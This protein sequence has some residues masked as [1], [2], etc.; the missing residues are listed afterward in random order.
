MFSIDKFCEDGYLGRPAEDVQGFCDYMNQFQNVV[1]WGAGNLGEAIGSKFAQLG[2]CVSAY[3]DAKYEEKKALNGIPVIAPFSGAF[4]RDSTMVVFC[5]ANVPMAP[6]LFAKLD[7]NGWNHR[8]RGLA[9]LQALLCPLEIGKP[10]DPGICAKQKICTVCS[11]ER[12]SSLMKAQAIGHGHIREEDILSFDRVHFIVNNFCNLKCTHCYM[13]MNSYPAQRKKNVALDVLERDIQLVMGAV[14][15]FGVVNVFGGEPF[16]HPQLSRIVEAILKHRNFGSLIV[17]TNGT[18]QMRDEQLEGLKDARVRLAFSNY[19]DALAAQQQEKVLSS[20]R[21]AQELGLNAQMMN[22]LP[23]WNISSTLC[24]NQCSKEEM[25]QFK[26]RCGVKFL[27]VFDHKVYPCAF[28]LSLNDLGVA[29]YPD[30][31]IDLDIADTPQKLREAI[32]ELFGR[33][34][35]RSCGHCDDLGAMG[36]QFAP[37]AGEQGYSERYAL[38]NK[39]PDGNHGCLQRHAARQELK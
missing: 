22:E 15:S 16:L 12:L 27:Y 2:I 21:H 18:A 34:Y 23:S 17:N 6:A 29:D 37:I 3:W 14:H 5:I 32:K 13:Y 1:L 31:Y 28:A 35:F 38:P 33:E 19:K 7:E 10:V 30:T 8:L 4:G 20:L 39:V 25:K 11:C 24:D 26:D 36:G 9:V